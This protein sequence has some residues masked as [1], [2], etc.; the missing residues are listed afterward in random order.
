[1]GRLW[2]AGVPLNWQGYYANEKRQRVILPT[3]PFE[4]QRYWIE[5]SSFPIQVSASCAQEQRQVLAPAEILADLKK[6]E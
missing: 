4:R 6:E 5:R 1:L 3:Y 2:L